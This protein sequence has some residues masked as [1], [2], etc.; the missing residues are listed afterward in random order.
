MPVEAWRLVYPN[1][2]C[3][4]RWVNI[5]R[6]SAE[7]EQ[8]RPFFCELH[9]FRKHM[10]EEQMIRLQHDLMRGTAASYGSQALV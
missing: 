8:R 7:I 6:A 2:I 9:S 3:S 1:F 10:A 5:E 4:D